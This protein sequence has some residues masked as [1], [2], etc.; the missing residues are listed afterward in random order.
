MDPVHHR[1]ADA[2][3]LSGVRQLS[4]DAV[5]VHH[6]DAVGDG[7]HFG[8]VAGDQQDRGA[9]VRQLSQQLVQV[10]LGL[11]VDPDHYPR[12]AEEVSLILR[13]ADQD[14]DN[15]LSQQEYIDMCKAAKNALDYKNFMDR[16]ESLAVDWAVG[17]ERLGM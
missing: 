3:I 11:D 14:F 12:D 2:V 5:A 17:R 15:S 13:L 4:G 10:G 7:D 1:A 8:E 16:D 9:V 6:H